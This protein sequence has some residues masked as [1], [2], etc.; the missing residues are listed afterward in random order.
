MYAKLNKR[1]FFQSEVHH[2][3][4]VVS[5][6]GITLDLEK[7]RAIMEWVAPKSVDDVRYFMELTRYYRRFIKNFSQI[8]HPMTSLEKKSKNLEWKEECEATF[9]QLKHLFTHSPMLQIVDPE[10][11]FVVCTYAYKRVLGGVLM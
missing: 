7:I 11:E 2:L 10:K 8:S 3:G 1:S 6:E 9:E 4:H 5:K